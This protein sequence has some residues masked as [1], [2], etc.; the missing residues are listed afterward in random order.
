MEHK[1]VS[2]EEWT[3]ARQALLAKEK[4]ASRAR[5][6]L[7]AERRALPWVKV[8]KSYVFEGPRGRETFA[9]LFAGKSQ[10]VVQHFML[11][12]GWK[13][14]CVGC[15]FGADNVA[16][17]IVHL[18]NH[19]VSYVAVSRASFTEIDAY[20]RRM[21]WPF[22]W[23]SSSPS[24]FNFDYHVSF[25]ENEMAKGRVYYN[26]RLT[27]SGIEELP[28]LSVFYKN[29]AGD[30]FHTYSTYGRGTEALLTAYNILDLT[31]KGR[32]EPSNL[33]DWVKRHDEYDGPR[34]AS[35]CCA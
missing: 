30:I 4:A 27:E 33:G 5:D 28:G 7:S 2:R 1:I 10:L 24:D 14:G 15:S 31:P 34:D 16:G 20:R 13:E 17:A 18:V 35:S 8:E 3:A 6:E 25:G 23:V 22:K 29:A 9:D 32:N 21:E 26:Y 19:D 12:P 11:G